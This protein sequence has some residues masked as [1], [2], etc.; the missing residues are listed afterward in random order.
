MKAYEPFRIK[1]LELK[2]RIVMPPMCM[3]S[4]P[5]SVPT[6]FHF[7]HY[8]ARALGGAGLIIV[9]ATGV[10]PEGRISDNCLGL[11][12]D[13]QIGPLSRL[14]AHV[15]SL[16]AKIG[17]QLNHAGRKC[18]AAA[19]KIF[20][21]S[22][23]NY[24]NDGKYQDPV[25]M[26]H[27]D[28]AFVTEAFAS[29]AGRALK[30][31]FDVVEIHGAHG[32][33]INQFLSP[34][35]NQRH[36]GYG[37]NFE[38]RSRFLQEVARAVRTAW[39]SEKPLFLRVSAEDYAEGGMTPSQ[40]ARIIDRVIQDV[41]VV[42]V[43]SGGVTPVPPPVFPGYQIPF[44]EMIKTACDVPTIAVGLITTLE[45]AEET[46]CN[47]RA[48]LVALGRELLRNPF[49]PLIEARKRGIELPWPEQY[50]RA[51]S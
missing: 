37:V 11:W 17:I 12:S 45:M 42:H 27:D 34:L 19:E 5:G 28:I 40:M 7:L 22:A 47:N 10:V 4:A 25:E 6:D 18:G 8:G 46:I 24:S 14:V 38:G 50:K 21:P 16:G 31:G 36:D 26:T 23:I 3:Y 1:E 44:A 49:F 51:F 41:D 30:A 29:A 15:H 13:D 32:Y 33:L 20:A 35:S 48:D 9:E 2:N 43:S 39:P